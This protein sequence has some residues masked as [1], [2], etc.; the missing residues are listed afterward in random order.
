MLYINSRVKIDIVFR[1]VKCFYLYC[2]RRN[3]KNRISE[4]IVVG[5]A[6]LVLHTVKTSDNFNFVS[7]KG[8]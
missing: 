1:D 5:K 4:E 8:F 2:S 3:I 7:G 6:M